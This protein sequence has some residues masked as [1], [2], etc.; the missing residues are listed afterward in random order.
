MFKTV[1]SSNQPLDCHIRKMRLETEGIRC[2]VFD[3][4]I[5]YVHPFQ[6][7]AIGGAKLK[8]TLK[9]VENATDILQKADKNE[10]IPGI[11]L[12]ESFLQ[13]EGLLKLKHRIRENP[14]LLEKPDD[15]KPEW[16]TSEDFS[17]L[18]QEE[19]WFWEV[20]Q[21][22]FKFNWNQ[23][24]YELIEFDR[25]FMKYIRPK[26]TTY[27]LLKDEVDVFVNAW[28]EYNAS[29][30]CHSFCPKCA[31]EE[32]YSTFPPA[33]RLELPYLLLSIIFYAP[34]PVFFKNYRCLSC[35]FEFRKK[36]KNCHSEK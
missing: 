24:W 9:D 14:E 26:N 22:E 29:K 11:H 30:K 8:V 7:V 16:M 31:S 15:L 12:Y 10:L 23:F 17:S 33:S 2:F 32:I 5:I 1:Y 18:M 13:S 28:K 27:F 6:A 3:E 19:K 36:K 21:K 20:S 4:N 25:N 35:G 34:F